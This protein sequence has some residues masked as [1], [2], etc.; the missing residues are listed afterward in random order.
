MWSP[1]QLISADLIDLHTLKH[2]NKN[3][4]YIFLFIDSFS[5]FITIY[6]LKSKGLEDIKR[7]LSQFIKQ[8]KK[9][10]KMILTD[11]EAAIMSREVQKL[12]RDNGI[13]HIASSTPR[14]SSHAEIAIKKIKNRLFRVMEYNNNKD[15]ISHIDD[16]VK[17]QNLTIHSSTLRQPAKVT[18]KDYSDIFMNLYG[19]LAQT[20][21]REPIFSPGDL[22][23]VVN[24]RVTF[25]R[26]Y[27]TRYSREIFRIR[28]IHTVFPTVS[29]KIED[30][31]GNLLD[32]SFTESELIKAPQNVEST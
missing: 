31:A 19:S 29:Y 4:S 26:S 7:A 32:S 16:I 8:S 12:F 23:R 18:S 14:K 20:P 11:H 9:R 28:S 3:F 17:S 5:K 6:K 24:K 15:W 13:T 2:Y 10:I 22:I 27:S 1:N 25:E 30:L 21:K